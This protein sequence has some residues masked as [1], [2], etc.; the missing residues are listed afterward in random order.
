MYPPPPTAPPPIPPP[1]MTAP[2]PSAAPHPLARIG[3]ALWRLVVAA[4]A[5]YGVYLIAYDP[6]RGWDKLH[7]LSQ[8]GS[9]IAAICFAIIAI[10]VVI[11]GG[12]RIEP[13]ITYLRGALTSMM[14]LICIVSIFILDGGALDQT[15][16]LFE[17]LIT[18]LLVTADFIFVGRAQLRAKAWQ[19]LTWIF[20][21]LGYM[22]YINMVGKAG[23]IYGGMLS[24]EKPTFLPYTAGFLAAAIAL[25][26]TVFGLTKL[27]GSIAG[28]NKPPQAPGPGMPPGGHPM[29]PQ[30]FNQ[31]PTQ[32]PPFGQAPV[33]QPPFNQPP[34]QHPGYPQQR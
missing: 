11:P 15:G 8:S 28:S 30:Q 2:S 27:R 1:P 20:I 14:L 24:A 18:P 12:H 29:P 22:I 34:P 9:L 3:T 33:G 10:T 4:S 19:P 7:F 17:H 25:N 6:V 23:S 5:F 16:F 21:A 32:Q 26:Y 31:P 13:A